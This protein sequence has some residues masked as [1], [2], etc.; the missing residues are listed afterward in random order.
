MG[1]EK[2]NEFWQNYRDNYVARADIDQLA[3]WGF[4]HIRLPFHYKQF[5]NSDGYSTPIGYAIVDTL[6]SLVSCHG[7]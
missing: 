1:D 7:A 5:H 4:N 6:L 3:E 2:A